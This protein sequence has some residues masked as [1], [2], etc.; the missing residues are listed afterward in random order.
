MS[1]E[2]KPKTVKEEYDLNKN[3]RID[4]KSSKNP[5]EAAN[6]GKFVVNKLAYRKID[7]ARSQ[8]NEMVKKLLFGSEL[9]NVG[10]IVVNPDKVTPLLI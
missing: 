7:N 9:L 1:E 2:E 3:G 4:P 5:D 8:I 6:F 10:K